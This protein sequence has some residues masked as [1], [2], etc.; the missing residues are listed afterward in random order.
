MPGPSKLVITFN[1]FSVVVEG[2]PVV[3]VVLGVDE[4]KLLKNEAMPVP[5]P[6]DNDSA[7]VDAKSD[8]APC[9]DVR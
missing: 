6:V 3:T 9:V 1:A 8:E 4:T 7:V 2:V 5:K